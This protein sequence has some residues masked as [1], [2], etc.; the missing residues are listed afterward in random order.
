MKR[1]LWLILTLLLLLSGCTAEE[2]ET[3]AT[4]ENTSSVETMLSAVSLMRAGF[5]QENDAVLSLPLDSNCTGI[6]F[7][8]EDLLLF[9]S[10]GSG[11]TQLTRCSAA[12]FRKEVSAEL[13]GDIS[14]DSG[15]VQIQSKRIGYY[16]AAENSIVI[17]DS[18]LQVHEQIA[19][20]EDMVGNPVL[21]TDLSEAYYCTQN[22]IR[23]LDLRSGISRLLRQRECQSQTVKKVL[24]SD[25]LLQC[26]VVEE[27]QDGYTD[28]ISTQTG[29][30][31]A[32]DQ[33]LA[34]INTWENRF[35]CQRLDGTVL[36]SVFGTQGDIIQSISPDDEEASLYSVLSIDSVL[37]ASKADADGV[38]LELYNLSSG[39][40]TS[41][42]QLG[43]MGSVSAFT[44]APDGQYLWFLSRDSAQGGQYLCRWDVQ[45]SAVKSLTIYTGTRYT[46]EDPD[47]EGLQKCS[48]I[49]QNLETQYGVTLHLNEGL[50]ETEIYGF[51]I[52]YQVPALLKGLE[53]LEKALSL[54]PEGFL[55]TVAQGTKNRQLHIALVRSI[56]CED[57][58]MPEDTRSVQ[59]WDGGST[60]IVLAISDNMQRDF[61]QAL[62]YALD[63]YVLANSVK[64]DAWSTLNPEGFAYD[65][66]YED[67]L[68]RGETEY[69]Q[70]SDRA[71][72]D[73]F[74]M[75]YARE[76]RAQIFAYALTE[77][78]ASYFSTPVM[79]AKLQQLCV[80]IRDAFDWKKD[81]RS[82]PWEQYLAESLA[83]VPK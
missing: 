40:K 69:L 22:Q 43:N 38:A 65:E 19:L 12:T 57:A 70:E 79:Q 23:A 75:T 82:F 78:N 2:P 71:F 27:G 66:N 52:E 77:G 26:F 74:S 58:S 29:E 24:L 31:V 7:M 42:T 46:A 62:Y 17:L 68:N 67:Y 3:S 45:A 8:G 41:A 61:C 13:V 25:G 14:P 64:L 83:Y 16:C 5:S 10:D 9:C 53:E 37:T 72:I 50:V 60:Y 39:K 35:F 34:W 51:E 28:F 30:T 63:T 81:A 4:P 18:K 20:P 56:S 6:A 21:S 33:E 1:W 47:T 32:T 44:A 49:G 80:A 54:F 48:M 76:D 15:S 11:T 55:K 36:E 73:S 59:Y